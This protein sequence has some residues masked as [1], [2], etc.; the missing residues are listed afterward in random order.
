MSDE[1]LFKY[2]EFNFQGKVA[3]V[4]GGTTGLGF[5]I[6]RTLAH[7][8]A[9]VM[10]ASYV[11]EECELAKNQLQA[12][13]YRVESKVVDVTSPEQVDSLVAAT[14]ATFGKVDILVANAGIGGKT[15]P[16][17]EQSET[18]WDRVLETNLKGV[19]LCGQRVAKQMISQESGGRIVNVASVAAL[20][21]TKNVAPYGASKAGVINLTKTMGHEWARYNINVNAVCPGYVVTDIN[22]SILT[23]PKTAEHLTKKIPLRRFGVPHEIAGAVAFLCSDS[24]AF[25][26]GA[27][28]TIDGGTTIGG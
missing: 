12:M 27:A 24:A 9:S 18:D 3:I 20:L 11:P 28:I 22:R 10:I 8:G 6:T 17:L 13:D 1:E 15:I 5:A 2:P 26:T 4:T 19:F 16:L 21:G 7:F 14:V 25:M 23:D